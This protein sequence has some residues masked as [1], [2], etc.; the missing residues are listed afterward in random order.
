MFSNQRSK[1]I[2][3]EIKIKINNMEINNKLF[4][5]LVTLVNDNQRVKELRHFMAMTNI[6]CFY[7]C[8]VRV[9]DWY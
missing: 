3:L 9:R 2:D 4:L 6:V 7:F 5:H 8:I 1:V